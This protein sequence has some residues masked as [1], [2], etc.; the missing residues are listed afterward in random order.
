[1]SAAFTFPILGPPK[2]TDDPGCSRAE[3]FTFNMAG[4]LCE[5]N[6]NASSHSP[7]INCL[8]CIIHDGQSVCGGG[9]PPRC[10]SSHSAST[11]KRTM[12]Q[13]GDHI[14]G[15]SSLQVVWH[16]GATNWAKYRNMPYKTQG[17]TNLDMVASVDGTTMTSLVSTLK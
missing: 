14:F 15:L 1:M 10:P 17:V 4:W 2:T 16:T 8:A 13:T 5:R 6:D 7:K 3:Q 9:P 11:P 12:I